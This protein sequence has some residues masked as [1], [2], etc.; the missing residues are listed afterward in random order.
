MAFSKQLHV[1]MV[2]CFAFI[3]LANSQSANSQ[4]TP[5]PQKIINKHAKLVETV[6]KDVTVNSLDGKG[7]IYQIGSE[8]ALG[9]QPA[10]TDFLKLR[11]AGYDKVLNFNPAGQRAFDE[12][13]TCLKA[14]M[15]Y[16]YLPFENGEQLTDEIFNQVRIALLDAKNKPVFLHGK[17]ND[18]VAAVWAAYRTLDQ[19]VSLETAIREAKEIG[20]KT[21]SYESRLRQ[22]VSRMLGDSVATKI[23][24]QQNLATYPASE[25]S[26]ISRNEAVF[27]QQEAVFYQ[28]PPQT[29]MPAAPS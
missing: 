8:I 1:I 22:Y 6:A 5:L 18:R 9:S 10:A 20:L 7:N 23:V 24:S 25:S 4:T 17:T 26:P 19:G 12:Q 16:Q 2:I 11:R 27:Y 28:Q 3:Q 15:A 29:F 14:G 13:T 21:V